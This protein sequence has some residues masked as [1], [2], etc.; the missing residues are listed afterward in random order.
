MSINLLSFVIVLILFFSVIEAVR[1]GILE[2]KYSLLW[3]FTCIIMGIL[4]ISERFI[5]WLGQLIGVF[6][7]PS[8]LFL[9][10]LIFAILL[11]FDLT[12]RVSKL[13]KELT[14][15]TQ[16]HAILMKEVEGKSS[17]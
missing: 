11:I 6:Y 17:L 12:R 15:L 5:N 16:E 14:N 9:F 8:L 4:S 3:I 7:P 1:R 10:G 2:T 13:N